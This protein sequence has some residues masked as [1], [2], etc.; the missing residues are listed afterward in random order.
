MMSAFFVR[1]PIVAMVISIIIVICGAISILSLPVSL[2]PDITPPEI[3][4]NATYPGADALTVES[5]VATPIE[6]QMSGVDNMNYMYSLNA[7]N[8]QMTLTIDFDLSTDSNTDQILSQMRVSQASPQLPS[9]VNDLG[10]TVQKSQSAPLM[11]V[12]LYSPDDRYDSLFLS[13]YAT[14]NLNDELTRLPGV[15]NVQISGAGQ[16]AMRLWVKPERPGAA[17]RHGERHHRRRAT[18]EHRK[19]GR[20]GG[21][22]A[23]AE[24]AGVHLCG[25]AQG[26]LE[27]EQD[28]ANIVIRETS[29]GGIIRLK[30]VGRIELVRQNYSTEGRF[31]GKPAAVVS[32]FQLPG[33][34]ALKCANAVK[35]KLAEL[36]TR[37]PAGL[38]YEVSLDTT[39]AVTEGVREIIKT[40]VEALVLVMI[41]VFVFL[42]SWR[43]T[44][45][46]LLAV[47][48]S[49]VGTFI[50]FP[51]L[52]FSV[53]TLSLF[54]LVL[55]I[56]L[57]VDDA[58]VV[59][60][61]VE[62][63][64]EDGLAPTEATIEA[65][66]E[67]TGPVV[68]IALVLSS[69]FFPTAF[70]PGITGGL[71]RQFAL[72]IAI[73][74]LISAFN[75]LTLSPALCALLLR[76]RKQG[77]G[78]IAMF[79]R[80]FNRAYDATQNAYV[81][82]CSLLIR[83]S[84]LG[85]ILLLGFCVLA[86]AFGGKLPSSFLPDEDQGYLYVNLQLPD[87]ASLQRTS[88][89]APGGIDPHAGTWR[90]VGYDN[91]RIEP[92]Q[93]RRYDLQCVLLRYTQAL[94]AARI[95]PGAVRPNPQHAEPE[96]R[97]HPGR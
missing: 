97:R 96:A 48:V 4:V 89:A 34:N 85:V 17:Q 15:S 69:V 95:A 22:R 91:D 45:I 12:A 82:G 78:P 77:R 51:V 75:A 88:A 47:P 72:T 1:R 5:S 53:N 61:A 41:V 49:L 9:A 33:T 2:F 40:L 67:I 37:F 63:K 81:A 8:G 55:A 86:G 46:P 11:V 27:T 64:I 70:L 57:V 28:F 54:G 35:A 60:E 90:A 18:A 80:G 14:I 24:G 71:Y 76:P 32:I 13:N 92:A 31:N 94:V 36:K 52:G 73:S 66:R 39:L 58:I 50:L 93:R 25:A 83:K 59:V 56:G 84:V 20:A 3:V 79:F 23:G 21:R 7:N 43:A 87:A 74:V 29:D 26:R 6:Q 62:R 44:L 10:V 42:Q 65:M 16:Y 68:G 19:L 30:D 38:D